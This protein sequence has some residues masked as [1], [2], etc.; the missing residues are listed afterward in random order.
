MTRPGEAPAPGLRTIAA[1]DAELL[2]QEDPLPNSRTCILYAAAPVDVGG[3]GRMSLPVVTAAVGAAPASDADIMARA[4]R[5]SRNT[6]RRATDDI[7]DLANAI[8]EN[9]PLTKPLR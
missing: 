4:F 5:A 6:L 3:S 9:R 7:G 8:R 1:L 2:A